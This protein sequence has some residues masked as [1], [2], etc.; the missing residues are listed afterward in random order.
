MIVLIRTK[1]ARPTS[2][3]LHLI[4]PVGSDDLNCHGKKE[5]NTSGIRQIELPVPARD[6]GQEKGQKIAP[7]AKKR[8]SPAIATIHGLRGCREPA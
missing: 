3:N 8:S 6:Q 4:E 7:P 1:L 5:N 2:I